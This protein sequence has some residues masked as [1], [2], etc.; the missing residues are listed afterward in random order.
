M[1]EQA[2]ELVGPDLE[3]GIEVKELTENTPLLGHSGGE[4]VVLIRQGDRISALGAS[5]SHYGGP[6]AEG[7]VVGETL[8][9][10]WHHA[11]FSLKTGEALGAPALS[12][13]ACF[14]VTRSGGRVT[15]GAK[16]MPPARS[17]GPGVPESVVVVGSGAAGAAAVEM[18]RQE[19]YRGPITFIGGE[20]PVDR[21]NLSKEYLAGTAPEEW[22]P[23]R[24]LHFYR[25]LNVE[26]VIGDPAVALDPKA[27]AV[28]LQSGRRVRYGA[29]LFAPGAEPVRL[30][31]PGADL[32][33]VR[34]LRTLDDSRALIQLASGAKQVVIVG[35]SF[36]GLEAAASLRHRGLAVHV[37]GKE[38]LPLERALGP[39]VGRFIQRL[40]AE[41]GVTFHLGTGPRS[42]S[43]KDVELENGEK[44]AADLVVMGVGVRPRVQLAEA[45]GLAVAN[46][47]TVDTQFRTSA[48]D[49]WASG[50]VASVP[51]PRS[52]KRVRIEH[53]VAAERQG[54]AAARSILGRGTPFLDVPF[55]WS[56]HYDVV[57]RTVG[58]ASSWEAIEIHGNLEGRD[59]T[60]AYRG[61]GAVL[62]VVTVG[63]DAVSLAAEAAMERGD[64]AAL[65]SVLR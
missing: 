18:L 32:P 21:P 58:H 57:L 3:A 26:L 59:A 41:Q 42:I 15:V 2:N 27:H 45:A 29:L 20:A 10:P 25:E 7:L 11:R 24:P 61:G 19:G 40:H 33:H 64:A 1:S 17:L 38:T 60:V 14:E 54:Q 5:C 47:V 13:V 55:F 6:L 30:R 23:L 8:R 35:A 51:D 22:I 49:V 16:K 44:L 28:T 39:E 4:A 48:P 31:I 43:A 46:G 36:I 52:G 34:T 53:W 12:A 50:D 63:R 37:V 9:C 65:E 62:Q 56:A